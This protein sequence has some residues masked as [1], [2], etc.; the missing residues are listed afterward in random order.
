VS[1][2]CVFSVT[3]WPD[4]TEGGRNRE[5]PTIWYVADTCDMGRVVHRSHFEH[6]AQRVAFHMNADERAWEKG[7]EK[8]HYQHVKELLR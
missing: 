2:Y 1:R 4:A 6:L 3:G 7:I 8:E 5:P